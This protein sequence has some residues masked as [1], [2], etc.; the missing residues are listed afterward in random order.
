MGFVLPTGTLA[1][2]AAGMKKEHLWIPLTRETNI[3][4]TLYNKYF[5]CNSGKQSGFMVRPTTSGS[6]PPSVR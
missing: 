6:F 4:S 5:P 3:C 1:R 2:G